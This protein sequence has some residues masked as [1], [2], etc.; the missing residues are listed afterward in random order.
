MRYSYDREHDALLI[1][2]R[3]AEYDDSQE[4]Y[5]GFVID[6]D[7]EGRPIGLDIYYDASKFVDIT[8]LMN[9]GIVESTLLPRVERAVTKKR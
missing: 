6:L 4:I 8:A 9:G 1:T 3:D 2:F 7:K 5:P